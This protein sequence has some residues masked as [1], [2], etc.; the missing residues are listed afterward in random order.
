MNQFMSYH[1]RNYPT[2]RNLHLIFRAQAWDSGELELD[3]LCDLGQVTE[4]NIFTG[5]HLSLNQDNL[6]PIVKSAVSAE[7]FLKIGSFQGEASF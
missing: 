7:H 3:A 5:H 2:R 4:D 1:W 6:C